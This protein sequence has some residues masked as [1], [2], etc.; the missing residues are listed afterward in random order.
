MGAACS[1]WASTS[2]VF[3]FP[4]IALAYLPSQP[5]SENQAVGQECCWL[6]HPKAFFVG[7][8]INE[9][10]WNDSRHGKVK[11]PGLGPYPVLIT[12]LLW[13]PRVT[14][15]GICAWR[16]RYTGSFRYDA[17]CTLP[18]PPSQPSGSMRTSCVFPMDTGTWRLLF[19]GKC[20]Q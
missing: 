12:T 9:F 7:D 1:K 13:R 4:G 15:A 11:P 14:P 8:R 16:F 5:S 6:A 18:N 10:P 2:L 3:A 20:L 17:V 19:N